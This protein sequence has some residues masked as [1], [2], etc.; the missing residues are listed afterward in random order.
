MKSFEFE[1]FK[2][3]IERQNMVY[4]YTMEE[5]Y[6]FNLFSILGR[7]HGLKHSPEVAR[8]ISKDSI[9]IVI[10]FFA[11]FFLILDYISRGNAEQHEW[12]NYFHSDMKTKRD[13]IP[14]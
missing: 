3:T 6:G 13:N 11:N 1:P 10:F 2:F 14:N 8:E 4:G 12:V 9:L 5:L 7:Y